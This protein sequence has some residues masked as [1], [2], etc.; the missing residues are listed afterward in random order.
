VTERLFVYGTLA[1]GRPNEHVLGDLA[2]TWEP[3]TVRGR[4]VEQGWGTDLGFP[5]LVL[6]EAGGEVAGSVF[7]SEH[8][9]RAWRMLDDFEG[10][11]YRRVPVHVLLGSGDQA[12]A[13]VYVA[14]TPA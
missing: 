7:T 6:D 3:A 13:Y 10:P 9:A 1:P 12:P 4:L 2:G 8:L 11:G 5:A 14:A